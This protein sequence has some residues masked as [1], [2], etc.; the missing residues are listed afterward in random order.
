[1]MKILAL[2]FFLVLQVCWVTV[3]ADQ[4]SGG[5]DEIENILTEIVDSR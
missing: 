1:M 5:Q 4:S 3:L 2:I